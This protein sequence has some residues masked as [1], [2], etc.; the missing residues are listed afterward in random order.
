MSTAQILHH[1]VI[2]GLVL[3]IISDCLFPLIP[4]Q[5]PSSIG[6]M[7]KLPAHDLSRAIGCGE[8]SSRAGL[9]Q[10]RRRRTVEIGLGIGP[11]SSLPASRRTLD[12]QV[13]NNILVPL[14]LR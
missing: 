4:G 13:V 5:V 8:L 12:A 2:G 6:G 3:R 7:K 1:V 9:V 14:I 11:R 10:S